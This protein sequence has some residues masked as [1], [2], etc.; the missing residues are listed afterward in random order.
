MTTADGQLAEVDGRWQLRFVRTLAHPRAEVWR[1]LTEPEHLAAWFPQEMQGERAVGA[2][3]RFVSRDV[4]DA[5]AFEGE[6]LVFEPPS[7]LEFSWGDDRLRFELEPL[8]DDHTV[9]TLIDTIVELGK[10]A[11]DGAG[12]HACL[13]LLE[14]SLAGVEPDWTSAD[15]WKDVHR[16]YVARFGPDASAIGPPQEWIDAQS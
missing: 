9:L 7:V 14:A 13:D 15:R 2:R 8:G 12:W 11:R 16:D 10:A 3:L 6:M 1:A 4:P 5:D